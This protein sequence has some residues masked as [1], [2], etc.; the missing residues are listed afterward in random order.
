MEPK[1]FGKKRN[2]LL[3]EILEMVQS[4]A[5]RCIRG[6]TVDYVVTGQT[7]DP[8][9]KSQLS[10]SSCNSRSTMWACVQDSSGTSECEMS[11]YHEQNRYVT[12][13]TEHEAPGPRDP[14]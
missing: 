3:V 5:D 8:E 2:S 4:F 11:R 12:G 10:F 13:D 6:P 1:S 14:V 7:G 9:L